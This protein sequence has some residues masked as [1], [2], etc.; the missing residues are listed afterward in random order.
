MLHGNFIVNR[1]GATAADVRAL[2]ERVR[3]AVL[4]SAGI[5][6]APE[7]RLLGFEEDFPAAARG[8]GDVSGDE[9]KRAMRT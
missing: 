2:M 1:G 5:E 3:A 4:A 8:A 6:L 7:V 9:C